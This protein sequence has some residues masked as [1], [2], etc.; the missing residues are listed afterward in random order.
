M[1]QGDRVGWVEGLRAGVQ[2]K[3]GV[4][5]LVGWEAYRLRADSKGVQD[6]ETALG[7]LCL[8]RYLT[9]GGNES[10]EP[11][12]KIMPYRNKQVGSQTREAVA[13]VFSHMWRLW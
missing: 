1:K 11:R 2:Q 5:L 10:A 12:Q 9:G 3:N 4:G 7:G 8:H 6:E 13:V